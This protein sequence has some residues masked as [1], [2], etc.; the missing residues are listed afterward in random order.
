MNKTFKKIAS[1]FVA[2]TT[3]AVSM[4]GM[5]VS[6]YSPTITKNFIVGNSTATATA[7]K[8]SAHA[9]ANTALSGER[10]NVTLTY[11]GKTA[12]YSNDLNKTPNAD[13]SGSSGTARS[14]HSAAKGGYSNSTSITV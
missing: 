7:F 10:C 4:I 1:S 11:C 2:V 12:L 6:A 8:D 5:N 9:I 3:L 14:S 13:I